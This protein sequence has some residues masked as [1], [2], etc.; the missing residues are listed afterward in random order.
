MSEELNIEDKL[1]RIE[2][3][4]EVQ[5]KRLARAAD[6]E[7]LLKMPEFQSVIIEGLIIEE[8]DRLFNKL[9]SPIPMKPEEKAGY[10]DQLETIRDI[11]RYIGDETYPGTVAIYGKNAKKIIDEENELKQRLLE[12]KGE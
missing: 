1:A 7:K 10:M 2:A 11:N 6:L 5:E 8:A 4:I 12:G 9:M 3:N